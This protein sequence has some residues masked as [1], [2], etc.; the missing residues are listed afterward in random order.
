MALAALSEICTA[1][2]CRDL[3]SE[4]CKLMG[5]ATHYIKKKAILA[6]TRIIRKV[7]ETID[8]FMVKIEGLMEEQHHGILLSTL[9][10]IDDILQLRPQN[11][12]KFKKFIPTL[13]LFYLF[14]YI[15]KFNF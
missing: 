14:C 6:A 10:L 4:V 3:A 9:A 15:N 12:N 1:D 2:M 5:T 13:V 11:K 7:P 8:E